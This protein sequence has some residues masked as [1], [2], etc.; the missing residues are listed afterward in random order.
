MW[1]PLSSILVYKIPQFFAR[2]YQFR[3]FVT[4]FYE[5]DTLR[6]LKIYIMFYRPAGAKYPFYGSAIPLQSRVIT[7]SHLQSLAVSYSHSQP[8]LQSLLITCQN[9][10]EKKEEKEFER[11]K[12]R[13]LSKLTSLIPNFSWDMVVTSSHNPGVIFNISSQELTFQ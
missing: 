13:H 5:V 6:L 9:K 4:F 3:Q 12:F 7:C 8:S 1:S 10:K 11:I 2:S